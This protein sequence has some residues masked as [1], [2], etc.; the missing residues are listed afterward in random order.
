MNT[1]YED[2]PLNAYLDDL[3]MNELTEEAQQELMDGELQ[4]DITND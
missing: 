3:G 1:Y 2:D 4:D